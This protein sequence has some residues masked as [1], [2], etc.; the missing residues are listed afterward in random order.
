[1][2]KKP[3]VPMYAKLII[4]AILAAR[5]V[6]LAAT[7]ANDKIVRSTCK[8]L[9]RG[10][11]RSVKKRHALEDTYRETCRDIDRAAGEQK[12]YAL[13]ARNQ[14]AAACTRADLRRSA[15]YS[16]LQEV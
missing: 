6:A 11:E 1:M 3:G 2:V 8:M 5:K 16:A 9:N 13:E 14:N 4:L 12:R 10:Y 15:I 7:Q